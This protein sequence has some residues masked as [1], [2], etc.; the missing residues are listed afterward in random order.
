MSYSVSIKQ[1]TE[2]T[3]Y[4]ASL[5]QPPLRSERFTFDESTP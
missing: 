5:P 3:A 4:A 1:I 2:L